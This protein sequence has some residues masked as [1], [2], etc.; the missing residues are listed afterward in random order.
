MHVTPRTNRKRQKKIRRES[1]DVSNLQRWLFFYI[2]AIIIGLLLLYAAAELFMKHL[3]FRSVQAEWKLM[4]EAV[5]DLPL[6]PVVSVPSIPKPIPTVPAI[7]AP[8]APGGATTLPRMEI[9][10]APTETVRGGSRQDI[11][12]L[13]QASSGFDFLVR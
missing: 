8:V 6:A 12:A 1:N 13:E 3:A 10:A 7:P 11:I 9:S 2:P 5:E 4:P